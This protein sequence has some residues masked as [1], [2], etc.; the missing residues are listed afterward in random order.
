MGYIYILS[1]KYYLNGELLKIGMTSRAVSKRVDELS[2]SFG[3]PDRFNL[4]FKKKTKFPRLAER[5]IHK[6]LSGYR[7]NKRREFFLVEE[8]AAIDTVILV[9]DSVQSRYCTVVTSRKRAISV[10]LIALVL[11]LF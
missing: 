7:V 1:N 8:S 2:S 9:C 10:A 11:Y 6:S 5:E 3:V 4:V